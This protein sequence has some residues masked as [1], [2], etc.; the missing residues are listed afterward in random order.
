MTTFGHN[1]IHK[2]KPCV[3]GG[4]GTPVMTSAVRQLAWDL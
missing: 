2:D 1:Y 4:G 3:E